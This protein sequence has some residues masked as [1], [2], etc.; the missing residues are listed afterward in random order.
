MTFCV[1]PIIYVALFVKVIPMGFPAAVVQVGLS[2]VVI[3]ISLFFSQ[4]ST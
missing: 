2:V 1:S 3:Q 4:L